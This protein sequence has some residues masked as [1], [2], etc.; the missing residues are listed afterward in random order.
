MLAKLEPLHAMLEK[1]PQTLKETSFHQVEL[2]GPIP[3]CIQTSFIGYK[4]TIIAFH[5]PVFHWYRHLLRLTCI[6]TIEIA[7]QPFENWT[8]MSGF[9]MVE[10]FEC[11]TLKSPGFRCPVFR[12]LFCIIFYARHLNETTFETIYINY[13]QWLNLLF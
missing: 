6:T 11:Q 2:F 3:Y 5:L 10:P 13:T 1:G 12:W 9:P 7:L 4:W 8:F